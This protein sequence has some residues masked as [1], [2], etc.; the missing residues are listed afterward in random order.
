MPEL[1]RLLGSGLSKLVIN[2]RRWEGELPASGAP[3]VFPGLLKSAGE[4]LS[5]ALDTVVVLV[6]LGDVFEDLV[7]GVDRKNGDPTA[8]TQ[9]FNGPDDATRLKVERGVE[10]F[11][12]ESGAANDG[13]NGRSHPVVLAQGLCRRRPGL[14]CSLSARDVIFWR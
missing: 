13:D 7:V 5:R 3:A 6:K 12:V 11:S 1:V 9:T 2:C 14:R 4:G 10:M 8:R